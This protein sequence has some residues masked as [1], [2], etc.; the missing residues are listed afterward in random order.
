MASFAK[1]HQDFAAGIVFIAVGAVGILAGSD[2]EFGTA[3]AMGTG[4]F[5][6]VT[7][8]LIVILGAILLI[9]SLRGQQTMPIRLVLR[10]IAL[11][12]LALGTFT[13]MIDFAGIVLTTIATV[14]VASY[15]YEKTRLREAVLLGIFAA[16][17]VV[18]VFVY[19]LGQPMSLWW[20]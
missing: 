2:L 13:V 6:V 14:V 10:P 18:G 17:F 5:P 8:W 7:S 4:Y 12:L 15:G 16:A 1:N 19:G 11:V 9:T 20:W 3:Q